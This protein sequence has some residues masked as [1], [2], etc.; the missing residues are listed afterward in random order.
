MAP[1]NFDSRI[2]RV[3]ELLDDAGIAMILI[4]S[5][6]NCRYL[7]GFTGSN[8][9]VL[10]SRDTVRLLTDGRYTAQAS[11]QATADDIVI[12]TSLAK[13]LPRLVSEYAG[14]AI[15]FEAAAFTVSEWGRLATET[16]G[17][18][19]LPVGDA[20]EKLRVCK[21]RHELDCI[22]RA[23]AIA[24][25]A[26]RD[27]EPVIQAGNSERA[28]AM[29]LEWKIRQA[30]SVA[31]PFDFIVASGSRSALPHGVATDA[32][33][34]SGKPLTLDFGAEFGGYFSDM[35]ISGSVGS[36]DSWLQEIMAVLQ[37]AQKAAIDACKPG[38]SCR[39][40]DHSARKIIADE[41]FGDAFSHSLGHGVGLAVH[42]APRL[43]ATSDDILAEGMVVTI[44]P[45]IYVPGTGGARIED[46][47]V[48]TADGCELLTSIPKEHRTW[49]EQSDP[50]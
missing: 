45:G 37:A 20:L 32:V 6:E 11:Q 34:Q 49:G 27:I 16:H 38:V 39:D 36:S 26:F 42:E 47:V 12:Y 35:T 18:D 1:M 15:G 2:S 9:Q 29:E 25:Q 43:A 10:V 13:E 24:E 22:A 50:G 3:R 21:D 41:G 28:V 8:G 48:I 33:I 17:T 14:S 46:M 5:A 40:V 23:A 44:E 19:W 30:G 31:V 7:T 4:A